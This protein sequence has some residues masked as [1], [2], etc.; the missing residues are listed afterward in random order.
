[1]S[2][3]YSNLLLRSSHNLLVQQCS[4]SRSLKN[5]SQKAVTVAT[6]AGRETDIK[7]GPGVAGL[8]GFSDCGTERMIDR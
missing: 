8:G 2:I 5:R 4:P 7:L 3:L 1:M 6:S